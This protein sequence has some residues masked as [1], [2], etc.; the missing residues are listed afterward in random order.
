MVLPGAAGLAT[1]C[2]TKKPLNFK[3]SGGC[4][5]AARGLSSNFFS[6]LVQSL[7]PPIF[8]IFWRLKTLAV[9]GVFT[10][11][12]KTAPTGRTNGL[13]RERKTGAPIARSTHSKLWDSGNYLGPEMAA[14]SFVFFSCFLRLAISARTSLLRLANSASNSLLRLSSIA[15]SL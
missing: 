5:R 12:K 11:P 1:K 6:P 2:P 10:R 15:S 3:Q 14:V 8:F 4:L 13:I 9:F 7:N